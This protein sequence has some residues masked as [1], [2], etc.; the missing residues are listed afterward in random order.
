MTRSWMV[1]VAAVG[2]MVV[3][4]L[5]IRNYFS[6]ANVVKRSLRAAIESFEREQML[7]AMHPVSR[8]YSDRWGMS[9]ESIA[10]HL[11]GVMDSFDAIE[12]A[13]EPPE[14]KVEGD[15][16]VV[17]MRFVVSG[18]DGGSRG[19]VF[20]SRAEPCTASQR[21]RKESQGWRI[22]T[23]EELDVPELRDELAELESR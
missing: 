20:G 14:V 16:A 15:E 18:S 2:V 19:Y 1:R 23:T 9:Y 13:L 5:V 11:R 21:W 3:L 17:R 10:G 6:P 4:T 8:S 22:V 12:V 7:G